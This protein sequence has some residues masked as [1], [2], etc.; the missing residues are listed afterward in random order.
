MWPRAIPMHQHK[1][2][3]AGILTARPPNS[4]S[5]TSG[6]ARYPST[7]GNPQGIHGL[8]SADGER[9]RFVIDSFFRLLAGG[10][11]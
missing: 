2:K 10:S 7:P 5:L 8:Y 1:K 9:R 4:L 3:G 11:C 6:F